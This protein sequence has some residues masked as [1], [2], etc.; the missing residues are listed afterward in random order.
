LEFRL[1]AARR[2]AHERCFERQRRRRDRR[3]RFTFDV[4]L[5]KRHACRLKAELQTEFPTL[6]SYH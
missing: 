3:R 5:V 1:Y 6:G 2:C 4:A